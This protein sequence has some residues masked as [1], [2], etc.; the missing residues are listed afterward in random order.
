MHRSKHHV[1]EILMRALFFL[2]AC[3]SVFCVVIICYFVLTSGLPAFREIGFADFIFGM[4]WRPSSGVYGIFPMIVG[5]VYV[6][7]LAML[8]GVPL[9]LA[10]AVFL[11][12]YCPKKIYSFAKNAVN[13]MAGIPSVVYGFFGLV[14][15]VPIMQRVFGTNG[16]GVLTAAI[17]LAIMILP[18]ITGVCE[19]AMRAVDPAYFEGALALGATKESAVFMCAS[20]GARSGILAGIVLA[21]GRAIGETMAVVM[22]AGNQPIIPDSVLSGVR[23]LTSNIILEMGYATDLHR[24]ALLATAAVLF[25]FILLINLSF[26]LLKRGAKEK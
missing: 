22:I 12:Y 18:T 20:R 11:A 7:G 26:S 5:S 8:I 25:V 21:V 14:V 1:K 10:S 15:I 2:C 19:S 24:E 4:E 23:T 13:L 16:K 6:S 17:I 9:G 3:I